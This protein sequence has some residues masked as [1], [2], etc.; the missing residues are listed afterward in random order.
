[1]AHRPIAID[2]VGS[3]GSAEG[4][5]GVEPG[6]SNDHSGDGAVLFPCVPGILLP[7]YSL[8]YSPT[9]KLLKPAP[10]MTTG[11]ILALSYC[12]NNCND[13]FITCRTG[14]YRYDDNE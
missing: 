8:R 13:Y 4:A 1:M 11:S 6:P 2:G 5:G 7:D 12:E 14:M 3:D 10:P 9:R